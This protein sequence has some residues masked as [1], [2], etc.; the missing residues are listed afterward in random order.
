MNR[1]AIFLLLAS[2]TSATH[3]GDPA[4]YDNERLNRAD[5][6]GTVPVTVTAPQTS[7]A[8]DPAYYDN[9]RISRLAPEDKAVRPLTL[10]AAI[11]IEP[12]GDPSF[13][14]NEPQR[15]KSGVK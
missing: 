14:D 9:E 6:S 8:G 15:L 7:R 11:P 13:Y 10:P 3:A 2:T 1:V 5:A 12:A 4:F